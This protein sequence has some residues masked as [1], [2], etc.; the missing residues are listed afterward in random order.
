[1]PIRR[2]LLATACLTLAT[3]SAPAQDVVSAVVASGN[4]VFGSASLGSFGYDP[5]GPNGGTIYAAGFGSGAE[6]RRIA[7]VDGVQEVTQV[8]GLSDWTLFMKGG[9][10]NNGGGQPTAGGFLLN[11]VAIGG[12]AA[13]SRIIVS[14]GGGAVTVSGARRND[15]TQ[16][17]Y[18]YDLVSG[19]FAALVTQAE[20]AV[21]AGLA[22]PV[23]VTTSSNL[24]RQYA[25]SGDGQAAYLAD[26]TGSAAFGGIYRADLAAGTVTRL[27]ADTD[28]NTELAVL[29]SG[30][31]DTILLRGGA[32]T[33]NLG[34]IDRITFDGSTASPRAV[35]VP[36]ARLADFLETTAA[37]ITTFS[38]TADAAGNVYL[39]NTDSSPDRRAILRL[40]PQGRLSKVVSYAE[41]KATLSGTQNPSAN[42]LR[43]QPRT[44]QHP[45]GFPVTQLLYAES[46]P[47]NLI[48]G[49]YAFKPGDFDRDN[50]LDAADLDLF[51][52]AVTV[53]S[54]STVGPGGYKFDLT[55]NDR[56]DWKDVQALGQF[57]EY[58]ADPALA[59]RVVPA[60]P[61]TADADLNGLVDFA[62]FRI[63]RASFGAS[64]K[65]FVQG[66]FTGDDQVT[67]ADLQAWVNTSGFRSAVVGGGVVA[68][69]L[70]QGEWSAFLGGL[71]PPAVPLAVPSGRITQFEAGY[72]SIVIA[73]SVTKTGGGTL[74]LD[75][76]NSHTG[77]TT[78]SAG[79]L[80]IA[81]PAA[82]ATSLLQTGS[83]ATVAVSAG[84][85]ATLGGL[86]LSAGGRLDVGTGRV[87]V[88][89]G[90]AAAIVAAIAA[91]R[92]D[93]SWSGAGGIGSDA[94]AEAVAAAQPRAVGWLDN[95]DG[96]L[97]FGYA[98][99][100]DTNL[101]GLVDALDVANF[102]AS[103][104]Y[105]EGLPVRWGDG[106]F[107][108]DGVLDI[109]DS[110]DLLVANLFDT[111][112][113]GIASQPASIAAVPEPAAGCLVAIAV[114]VA[115]LHHRSRRHADRAR[116]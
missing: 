25:F 14:D 92:G 99:I 62:D 42:T 94:V 70:D 20:F 89:S 110:T 11:P 79:T 27:L 47:L 91:G 34:G 48:A 45:N 24:G 102:F 82:L 10:P 21:A 41:R 85:A 43:M 59:G 90:T 72:R 13:F 29:S 73:S 95:G 67:L 18:A 51:R 86:D 39:N 109:L 78:V 12:A 103:A 116:A 6:I 114:A 22:N 71:T 56:A 8:V 83:G 63:L 77:T 81:H 17:L 68:T 97:T 33:G 49:A 87:T 26:S 80:E 98:G 30:G 52:D 55:G 60:L 23:S 31:V 74:V 7:N 107:N 53:R 111:G 46:T 54:G 105:D 61:I 93:G 58:Q 9:D 36:A 101:D 2:T 32:S 3:A 1:M 104:A 96:S 106:D 16:R 66:D 69:P 100:G 35:H 38:M 4:A 76:A 28:T 88:A 40:D 50:D 44:V 57:L 64:A 84:L 5:T 75:G 15:L 113:Y 37:D 112:P 65:S 115:A 108:Y 19:S